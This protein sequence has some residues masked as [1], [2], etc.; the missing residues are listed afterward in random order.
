MINFDQAI[1]L[2]KNNSDLSG[3]EVKHHFC[4]GV[5]VREMR[6]PSGTVFT[7]KIHKHMNLNTL[8]G[9]A[10]IVSRNKINELN[11]PCVFK[12]QNGKEKIVLAR[13]DLILICILAT[14]KTNIKEIEE[15]TTCDTIGEYR[16]F[17]RNEAKKCRF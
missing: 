3:I 4:H 8:Y 16:E 17:K 2:V 1:E 11:G 5:Y 9:S 14:N 7:T 13:T 12:C 6:I 15:D 10:T